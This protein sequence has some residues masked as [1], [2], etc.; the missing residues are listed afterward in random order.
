[1]ILNTSL[2]VLANAADAAVAHEWTASAGGVVWQALI[3]LFFVLLNGFFVAS[4]FAMV[5]VRESQIEAAIEEGLGG[6]KAARHAT[7]HLDAYLSATQLGITLCSIAL[8]MLGEPFVAGL[9]Q[10]LLFKAGITSEVVVHGVSIGIAYAFITFLHVVIGEITPKTLAI[11][12]AL[13]TTLLAA[14]VLQVF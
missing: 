7:K 2:L 9:V 14:P 3:I 5:K 1:M 8:G 12:K 4:E 11:R 13:S 10:P 6:A